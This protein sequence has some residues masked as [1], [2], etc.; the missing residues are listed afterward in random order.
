T[1]TAN[2]TCLEEEL[3]GRDRYYPA[4]LELYGNVTEIYPNATVWVT[5]HSLGGSVGSLL[6]LTYQLPTVTFEAPPERLPAYRL[7]LLAL[8]DGETAMLSDAEYTGAYHFGN[9]ADPVYMGTCNGLFASCTLG[10][11]AFESQC[12]SGVRCVYDT[13]NDL[14]WHQIISHHSIEPLIKDVIELYETVPECK[15]EP[16]CVDCALWKFTRSISSG[17]VSRTTSA[18]TTTSLTRTSNG[19]LRGRDHHDNVSKFDFDEHI[20]YKHVPFV[21]LVWV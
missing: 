5:G 7:G 19:R 13:V 6:G 18:T 12:H 20:Y 16:E 17:S 2:Q 10:G 1:Y 4:V 15:P 14:Q 11:Y 21:G 8:S 9:T 3:E